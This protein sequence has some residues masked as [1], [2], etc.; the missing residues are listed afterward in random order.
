MAVRRWSAISD[1]VALPPELPVAIAAYEKCLATRQLPDVE[2]AV[3]AWDAVL[4]SPAIRA[5]P[6]ARKMARSHAG[7]VLTIR[8]MIGGRAEDL[9]RSIALHASTVADEPPGTPERTRFL[10]ALARALRMRY[11]LRADPAD[12]DRAIE[13]LREG[14]ATTADETVRLEL[15][16]VL[17]MR[18]EKTG[19]TADV[20]E[21]IR[22]AQAAT[23]RWP[24]PQAYLVLGNAL[25]LRF[26]QAHDRADLDRA[27]EVYEHA[28]RQNVAD[29]GERHA[30]LY[31]LG[32]VLHERF[33]LTAVPAD[34]DRAIELLRGA[35]ELIGPNEAIRIPV[36]DSLADALRTRAEA[37]GGRTDLDDLVLGDLTDA[38]KRGGS[39]AVRRTAA[40]VDYAFHIKD[41]YDRV[42][43]MTE[44][45]RSIGVL[46]A[47]AG[48]A[49]EESGVMPALAILQH[50]RY[51]RVGD[52]ADLRAAVAALWAAA[53]RATDPA[54]RAGH[55]NNL[56]SSL[57]DSYRH[58]G[59]RADLHEAIEAAA[60]ALEAV[61]PGSEHV[62]YILVSL[63]QTLHELYQRTGGGDDLDAAIDRWDEALDLLPPEAPK[64][65]ICRNSLALGLLDRFR[66]RADPADVDRSI[67]TLR[68][69]IAAI[70]EA[71]PSQPGFRNNLANALQERYELAGEATDLEAAVAVLRGAVSLPQ[72]GS[73]AALRITRSWAAWATERQAWPEAAEA[74]GVGLR[75]S[76]ELFA[77]QLTRPDK[78][79]WLQVAGE[80]PQLAAYAL[81]RAGDVEGAV[82]ALEQ[83]RAMLLSEA[84]EQA[85]ADLEQLSA[86]GHEDLLTVYREAADGLRD[87]EASVLV[88][89]EAQARLDAAADGIRAVPGYETFLR[90]PSFAEIAAAA[91]A[92][93]IVYLVAGS[94]GG[95]ALVVRDGQAEAVWTDALT[96]AALRE[97]LTKHFD[98]YGRRTAD[99]AGWMAALDRLTGWLWPAA[100]GPVLDALSGHDRAVLVPAGLLALA[101]LHAAWTPAPPGATVTGRVY[102]IDRLL[103][104]YA[105]NARSL[106]P[107]AAP[108]PAVRL[109]AVHDPEP[110]AAAPLP[111][112]RAEVAAALH[113]FD[114]A[115]ELHGPA[116]TVEAVL[117][118]LADATVVH[119][120]CHG[121]ADPQQPLEGGLL[122]AGDRVLRLRDLLAHRMPRVR[123]AVLSAC[124]T[125]VIGTA[126][127]EE[128]VGLPSG[129]LQAGVGGVASTLW[130]VDDT[131]T[132]L[133]VGYFYQHYR[134]S[135][136]EALRDCQ[137]WLRDSTNGEKLAAFAE[138]PAD[139]NPPAAGPL[140]E[141]WAA[142]RAYSHP[143][144]WAAFTYVG[145]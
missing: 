132:A 140:R 7:E 30:V 66:L 62:P 17:R 137:R 109:L 79:S 89:R 95:V 26:H 92:C 106:R 68:A 108:E 144:H 101:P 8:Y 2:A 115:R 99:R 14:A 133:L 51:E 85:R 63:G 105:P 57:R 54:R 59:D 50:A 58:T 44:L 36:L 118:G 18:Y 102:G 53:T 25:R 60:R 76:R 16:I 80:L 87:G 82:T 135:P 107:R 5:N 20:D 116:A 27:I 43:S 40:A 136:A 100:M 121:R 31:N 98:A 112:A 6:W 143:Y 45:D 24:A 127:P 84:L 113:A 120:A 1:P 15:A 3:A 12:L 33:T 52:L 145:W 65:H 74:V 83:G 69:V 67:D 73:A 13:A 49:D 47:V 138:P 61:D 64:R 9:D 111:S 142:A 72:C 70:P 32:S 21:A 134:G 122:L 94:H 29:Q 56:V 96:G 81:A 48:T 110:T 75:A 4:C 139:L 37:T 131:A 42:G 130:A 41:R 114:D 19:A 103:L 93:P 91:A 123:L 86:T 97:E 34:L 77:T 11:A 124:E 117:A 39:G 90:P 129:L 38:M 128:V 78:E 125:G 10:G 71:S 119:F 88:L 141:F 126:L 35:A 28:Y 22:L 55:Y 23:E 46:R 104:T